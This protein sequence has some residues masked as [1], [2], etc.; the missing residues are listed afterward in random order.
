VS[1]STTALLLIGLLVAFAVMLAATWRRLQR[2]QV[3]RT[4]EWEA[5]LVAETQL[6][7]ESS[8]RLAAAEAELAAVRDEIAALRHTLRE[9]DTE[10]GNLRGLAEESSRLREENAA[11]RAQS[12]A[13]R[14]ILVDVEN[15]APPPI[16]AGA[17]DDLKLIVGVGPVLERLLQKHGVT[18]F[19]QIA[20]WTDRDI[21][22]FDV[23]LAEFH[24]RV[25]RDD[26]VTQARELH[27]QKYGERLAK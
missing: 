14:Q 2:L 21:D 11:L 23:R 3:E 19:R 16:L 5:Q 7:G 1:E 10:I 27:Y 18:T 22:E 12:A 15:H 26:W 20:H 25:R 8:R 4:R 9:R 17:A 24:G 13:Y 6:A